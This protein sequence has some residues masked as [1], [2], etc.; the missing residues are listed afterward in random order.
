MYAC[1]DKHAFFIRRPDEGFLGASMSPDY[2]ARE[3]IE[4]VDDG[5]FLLKQMEF[6]TAQMLQPQMSTLSQSYGSSRGRGVAGAGGA[7]GQ[8][9]L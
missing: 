6:F 4:N 8:S 5:V 1:L 7:G 2:I 3:N 9:S